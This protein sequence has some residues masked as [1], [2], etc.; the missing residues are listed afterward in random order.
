[1]KKTG[2]LQ[3]LITVSEDTCFKPV[4]IYED[5]EGGKLYAFFQWE[6]PYTLARAVF[7]ELPGNKQ[8]GKVYFD[9]NENLRIVLKKSARVFKRFRIDK[10]LKRDVK[11]PIIIDFNGKHD[12]EEKNG[13]PTNP[14]NVI[15]RKKP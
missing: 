14:G 9:K 10:T 12:D 7:S 13:D 8:V 3:S 2:P 1:M 5:D 6:D 4:C 15:L 11:Y